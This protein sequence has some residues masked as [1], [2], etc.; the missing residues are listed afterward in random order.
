M[1]MVIIVEI[2]VGIVVFAG[3]VRFAVR[4]ARERRPAD[5]EQQS[6]PEHT[7]AAHTSPAHTSPAHTPLG[8]AP[9]VHTPEVQERTSER[10]AEQHPSE[11]PDRT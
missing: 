1:D 5:L 8:H 2:V 6:E 11:V 3:A 10:E 4:D 7:P 9:E